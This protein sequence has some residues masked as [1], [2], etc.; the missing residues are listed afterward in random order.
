MRGD[1]W[2]TSEVGRGS[3]FHFRIKVGVPD[4]KTASSPADRLDFDGLSVLIVEHH[5]T[6][7]RV[8]TELLARRGMKPVAAETGHE[9]VGMLRKLAARGQCF[10]FVL[11][12]AELPDMDA[13]AL[14]EKINANFDVPPATIMMLPY[15]GQHADIARCRQSG[16]TAHLTKPI[17]QHELLEA[18]RQARA[19]AAA[20]QSAYA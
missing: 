17:R 3:E 4:A 19:H 2:V 13:F 7:R 8:L 16:V 14:V 1:I 10:A 11:I 12:A 5:A 20:V 9:A 15:G 6:S 18:F